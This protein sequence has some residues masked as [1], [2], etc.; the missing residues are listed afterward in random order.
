MSCPNHCYEVGGPWIEEDPNCPVHGTEAQRRDRQLAEEGEIEAAR[1]KTQD[2]R[3][4]AL[5]ALVAALTER[6]EELEA[7]ERGRVNRAAY[8]E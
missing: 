8:G 4:T 3:I 5:E 6:V 2:E 1:V 7:S